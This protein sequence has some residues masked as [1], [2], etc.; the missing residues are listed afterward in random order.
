MDQK[1]LLK[2][3]YQF[4]I[5]NLSYEEYHNFGSPD[6]FHKWVETHYK[7]IPKSE[8]IPNKEYEGVCRNASK[9]I[10]NGKKFIYTRHKFGATCNEEINHYRINFT[11][12][13]DSILD[14]WLNGIFTKICLYVEDEKELLELHK[15]IEAAGIPCA[16]ITDAGNTEFHGVPTVTCLGIGPWWSEYIDEFTKDLKLF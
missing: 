1:E 3:L 16:L 4:V 13:K 12:P 9:A 5:N 2:N 11:F 6:N 10:W 14:K 15:K 7:I 8:L